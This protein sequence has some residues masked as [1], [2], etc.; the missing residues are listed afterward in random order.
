MYVPNP[1]CRD[2]AKYEWIGQLMG[3]AL[4]GKEFLVSN[5]VIFLSAEPGPQTGRLSEK[6][7]LVVTQVLALP[8][9]VW[10]QLSGEEVSW[11]KDFPA[12]DSVLVSKTWT[13]LPNP[14][15]PNTCVPSLVSL[16]PVGSAAVFIM[17]TPKI[18]RLALLSSAWGHICIYHKMAHL[19]P[20]LCTL[21]TLSP[22]HCLLG[23]G[24]TPSPWPTPKSSRLFV[25]S[26]FCLFKKLICLFIYGVGVGGCMHHGTH[27]EVRGHFWELVPFLPCRSW[28]LN[29]GHQ[30]WWQ[31]LLCTEPSCQPCFLLSAVG[32]HIVEDI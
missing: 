30:T 12:V 3:A 4:R 5:P 25:C 19:S 1:S 24:S 14:L 32:S 26:G 31:V 9:F 7:A 13:P 22:V 29:S 18:H 21:F 28:E 2:F 15:P 27:V 20:V 23:S 8:G 10:K 17:V 6:T 11:S 16:T